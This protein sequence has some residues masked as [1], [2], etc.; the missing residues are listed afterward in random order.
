MP[1]RDGGVCFLGVLALLMARAD[2]A[3]LRS[4]SLVRRG[5][6]SMSSAAKDQLMDLVVPLTEVSS[7]QSFVKELVLALERDNPTAAPAQSPLLDGTWT[8]KFPA[9]LGPGVIDSPTRELALALYTKVNPASLL[10]GFISRLPAP[11]AGSLGVD[12]LAVTFSGGGSAMASA[13]ASLEG[14]ILDRPLSICSRSSLIAV[15]ASRL[16]ETYVEASILGTTVRGP[17][18]GGR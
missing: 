3:G 9:V 10:L 18:R 13:E 12:S 7:Q 8:V 6:M 11:L 15:S 5:G 16:Q 14:K 2:C 17:D 4:S 1:Q